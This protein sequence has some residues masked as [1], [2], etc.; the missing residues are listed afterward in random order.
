MRTKRAVIS[1]AMLMAPG[2]LPGQT[3]TASIQAAVRAAYLR[4]FGEAIEH[5]A[6]YENP[7]PVDCRGNRHPPVTTTA[8]LR[9]GAATELLT[10]YLSEDGLVQ[11]TERSEPPMVP[12]GTIRVLAILV[13]YPETVSADALA[14]WQDAQKGINEEHA[15]FAR[16]RGY[17]APIVVFDNTNILMDPREIDDPHSP[18]SVRAAARRRGISTDD[19]QI[20][21]L[22]D[23]NPNQSA[24]GLSLYAEKSIYVGN[25]GP[26]KT[27]LDAARWKRVAATAYHHEMAHH[28]GWPGTHDWVVACGGKPPEFAP[29]I[30]PP[31]LFGWEDLQGHHEPEI[32][33]ATPYG[34]R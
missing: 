6:I 33:S 28:W 17:K 3:D 5:P 21:M 31:V 27:P 1:L 9:R 24:G 15:A 7:A 16:N 29:F 13:R 19:Y 11:H 14:E 22:I 8:Y 30:V 20:H 4:Q 23:I 10:M 25:Y 18:A 12:A 34:R 26:W 32:L 2:A